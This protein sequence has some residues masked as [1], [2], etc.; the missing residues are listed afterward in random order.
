MRA[1]FALFVLLLAG[2]C[3]PFTL[4]PA[5]TQQSVPGLTV[6]PGIAHNR[7]GAHIA[8]LPDRV[9]LWTIDGQILDHMLF[10]GGVADGNAV[11]KLP[12]AQQDRAEP[13]PLFRAAMPAGDIVELFA[14]SIVRTGRTPAVVT[15]NIRP[16]PFLETQG[17]RFDYTYSGTDEVDRR[18]TA[19]G[20][21]R[22]GR[23]YMIAFEGTQLLHFGRQL[24]EAERIFASARLRAG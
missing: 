9:E 11:L 14:A 4:V 18:G 5:N 24:P 8:N 21:V 2:A 7:M 19:I 1:M 3:A 23:L 20:A 17:F 16:A 12:V 10:I 13:M 15:Q 6:Q 22:D